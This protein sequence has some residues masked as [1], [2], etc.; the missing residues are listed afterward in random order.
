MRLDD[1]VQNRGEA[2]AP[3]SKALLEAHARFQTN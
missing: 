1:F 2:L 3:V